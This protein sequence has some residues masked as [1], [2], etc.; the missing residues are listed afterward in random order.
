MGQ[1]PVFT[2]AFGADTDI[3]LLQSISIQNHAI[4]KRIYEGSDAALQLEDFYSQISSPLLSDLKFEYVGGLDNSSISQTEVNTFFKSGEFVVTGKLSES[5]KQRSNIGIRISGFGKDGPYIRQFDVCLRSTSRPGQSQIPSLSPNPCLYHRL[6]PKSEAQ[7]FLQKLFAFQHIKQL[8]QLEFTADSEEER[9]EIKEKATELSIENNFVTDLTSLVVVKPDERPTVVSLE[10]APF[11]NGPIFPSSPPRRQ[12]QQ[13]VY[14]SGPVL[15]GPVSGSVSVRS[16]SSNNYNNQGI[17]Q[18]PYS[19][20]VISGPVSGSVSAYSSS[21]FNNYN[22]K[23]ILPRTST[24]VP[25]SGTTTVFPETP[26]VS[27]DC[28]ADGSL[29]LYSRTYHRGDQQDLT[30]SSPDLAGFARTA[31]TAK[32]TGECCWQL[33]SQAEYM[34]DLLTLR[35]G[36][37][38]TSVTS[39]GNLFRNA[40]SVRKIQC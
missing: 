15:S 31:V 19:G 9:S 18:S 35:P 1:I 6:Y 10:D 30:D 27:E 8:L 11:H 40:V 32:L 7:S 37:T 2:I 29:S 23:R 4:S 3:D 25:F 34:G 39:L 16:S 28:L 36:Q 5:A 17:F 14:Y 20:P 38:Y 24:R 13:S 21:S 33:Y 26:G 22:N 12:Q